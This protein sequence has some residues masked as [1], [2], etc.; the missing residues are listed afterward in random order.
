MAKAELCAVARE[1]YGPGKKYRLVDYQQHVKSCATCTAA[2]REMRRDQRTRTNYSKEY[3]LT[4]D[5][6]K[7]LLI[8][9]RAVWSRVDRRRR[10]DNVSARFVLNRLLDHYATHGLPVHDDTTTEKTR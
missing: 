6:H 1:R 5:V 10:A 4:G 8:V 9:P 3:P 7:Y 2:Q